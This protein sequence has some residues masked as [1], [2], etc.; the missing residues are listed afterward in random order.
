MNY[1]VANV[2]FLKFGKIVPEENGEMF[3]IDGNLYHKPILVVFDNGQKV[4]CDSVPQG[5]AWMNKE[6]KP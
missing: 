1:T 2:R 5:I 6:E 3:L 4:N